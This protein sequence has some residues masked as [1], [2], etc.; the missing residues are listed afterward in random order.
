M[1]GSRQTTNSEDTL[2]SGSGIIRRADLRRAHV[3]LAQPDRR[4]GRVERHEAIVQEADRNAKPGVSASEKVFESFRGNIGGVENLFQGAGFDDV[5]TRNDD[6]ML[7]VGH[8]NIFAFA[9]ERR[10]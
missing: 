2:H 7:F 9:E 1:L 5:M 10:T 6:N 8:R 3:E 4:I